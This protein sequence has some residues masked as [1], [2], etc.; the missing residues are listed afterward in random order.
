MATLK[1][2]SDEADELMDV[3]LLDVGL[4]DAN[5]RSSVR[6]FDFCQYWIDT[7]ADSNLT[8]SLLVLFQSECSF[9][10]KLHY[11]GL[12]STYIRP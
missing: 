4:P 5:I 9:S 11:F 8:T 6:A 12:K 10:I 3:Y 1:N 2:D 7:T